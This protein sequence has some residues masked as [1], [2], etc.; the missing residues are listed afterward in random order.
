MNKVSVSILDCDFKNIA[1]EIN[2]IN[3]SN[4][5]LIHID[6]MDGVFVE[7]NTYN[8]FDMK[9]I[10]NLSNKKLDV[11][12][13]VDNPEKIIDNYILDKTDF[14]S[15]HVE[16]KCDHL[17]IFDKLKSNNIKSGI[18]INPD[19]DLS[20]LEKYL[21]YIDMILI[22]SVYPG[23]G[24]QKF[25]SDTINRLTSLKKLLIKKSINIQL[26]VDGGVDDSISSNLIKSGSDILVSGSF[27]IKS[28]SLKN[29]IKSLLKA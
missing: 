24:G 26:S 11:H 6:I 7:R 20:I 9:T 23:K 21:N 3:K 1:H 4:A 19:T 17:K 5:D 8:L 12:L 25:L 16:S 10:S 13:M 18:A 28:K 14:I 22:M 15:I 27:L 2:R 29:S